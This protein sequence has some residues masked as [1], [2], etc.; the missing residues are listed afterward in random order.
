MSLHSFGICIDGRLS[1]AIDRHVLESHAVATADMHLT[2][3]VRACFLISI[4]LAFQMEHQML[5]VFYYF[6]TNV[7]IWLKRWIVCYNL[8]EEHVSVL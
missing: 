5:P 4:P 7:F 2:T 1:S 8:F 3:T 6:S